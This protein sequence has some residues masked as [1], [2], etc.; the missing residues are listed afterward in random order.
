MNYLHRA[1]LLT[2]LTLCGGL[3]LSSC[4]S[5]KKDSKKGAQAAPQPAPYQV[6]PSPVA[7]LSYSRVSVSGGPYL[8]L[9]F[10]DGPH[11]TN[12]PRLLDIL[13]Q[14][15]VKATFFVVGTNAKAHPGILKRMV[16]E[17]HEIA[18]H[19]WSHPNM[20]TLSQASLKREMDLTRDAVIAATGIAPR[21]CRPPYGATN[22]SVKSFLMSEYRYPTIMWSVDPL[23]WKQPGAAAVADRLVAGASNGGILLVH[24]IHKGSVDA[25]PDTL[26]RLLAQGYKFVTVSQL[27]AM[28]RPASVAANP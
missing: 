24:D 27:L 23:D 5:L 8:A 17:G 25:M 21:V 10:D 4:S 6:P 26:D 2:I 20:T 3:F 19:T 7:G 1:G 11:A 28:E 18:N 9:T 22:A 12:T 13:A 16:A 15:G 14:R